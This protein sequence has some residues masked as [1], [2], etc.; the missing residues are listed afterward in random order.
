MSELVLDVSAVLGLALG[1][2]DSEY[3]ARVVGA[4][5][6]YGAWVPPV[7]WYELRNSLLAAERRKRTDQQAVEGFLSTLAIIPMNVDDLPPEKPVM[8]LARQHALTVYDAAYL[9]LAQRRGLPIGTLDD[10]I[11]RAATKVG[12]RVL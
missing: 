1:D 2:E 5:A 11:V 9:E 7:F 3:A 8:S 10:A 4:A 12:V 6:Q